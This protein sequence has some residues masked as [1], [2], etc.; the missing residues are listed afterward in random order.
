MNKLLVFSASWCGPCN[1]MKPVV[2]QLDQNRVVRYDIDSCDD[3]LVEYSVKAVPT[4]IVVDEDNKEVGRIQG[5][6]TLSKLQELLG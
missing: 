1:N 4:F 3:E 2:N 6:T 5:A